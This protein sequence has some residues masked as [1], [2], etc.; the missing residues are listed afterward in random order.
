MGPVGKS[1]GADTGAVV[2]SNV[3]IS[4]VKSYRSAARQQA[5]SMAEKI[6]N[7]LAT[8]FAQQGWIR[9]TLAK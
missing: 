4:G 9:P 7:V 5:K 8:Y 1:A 6:A 3:G 2:A